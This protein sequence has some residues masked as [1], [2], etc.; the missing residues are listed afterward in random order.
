MRHFYHPLVKN[1]LGIFLF[2]LIGCSTKQ[3]SISAWQPATVTVPP[4]IQ[5]V[6]LVNRTAPESKLGNVLEG[7]LTGEMPYQDK[8]AVEA[9]M[10]SLL[11]S[12]AESP[13]FRVSQYGQ[14]LKGS[15]AGGIFPTPLDWATLGQLAQAHGADAI[16]AM[17]TF[18]SDFIVTNAEKLEDRREKDGTVTKIK[19]FTARGVATIK[20][21]LRLYDVK[22]KR[23]LDQH[24]YQHANT[25]NAQGSTVAE[26][27]LALV[28]KNQAILHV[29]RQSGY[30]YGKRIVPSQIW[31]SR[32]LYAKKKG[33]RALESGTR[34][35]LSGNWSGAIEDWQRAAQSG[36][37]KIAGRAAYNMAV[38]FEVSG[39]FDNALRWAQKSYG[40]FGLKKALP[41]AQILQQRI[42]D[43][44]RLK[45][46]MGN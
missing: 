19:V 4:H 46:Q 39:D 22:E 27:A 38:A 32:P 14:V 35:G 37:E 26:A 29:S 28:A 10:G 21:G 5:H 9:S 3:V 36:D 24:Q 11:G 18:D 42:V 15:G 8:Q 34:K 43:N 12:L 13:R 30:Q 23:L 31:L 44:V 20:C 16:L 25:W 41:Y 7:V 2:L 17:E 1:I 45:E 33:N 6:L 40:D